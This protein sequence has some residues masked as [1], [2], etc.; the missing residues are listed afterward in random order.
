MHR[1]TTEYSNLGK[2]GL[3][4]RKARTMHP[5]GYKM[6][7]TVTLNGEVIATFTTWEI[8][9][10]SIKVT[11]STLPTAKIEMGVLWRAKECRRQKILVSYGTGRENDCYVL[12][13]CDTFDHVEHF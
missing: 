3:D 9:I 6:I 7:T 5:K 13:E 8:A 10:R 11:Y 12:Q 2:N 1:Q 4:C